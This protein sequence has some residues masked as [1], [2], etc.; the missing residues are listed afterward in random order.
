[1][2]KD[3]R[4]Y[5][6]ITLDFPDHAK[7]LPL[8]DAAFRCL[9]EAIA[10][11]RKHL[12]DGFLARRYALARWS[13]EV[14]A[15]LCENDPVKPS[16]V[17]RED[18]WHIHDYADMNDT[19]AEVEARRERNRQAGKQGGL[20]KAKRVASKSL[21]NSVSENVAETETETETN[22]SLVALGGRVT[23]SN[24]HEPLPLRCPKHINET[25]PVPPCV[26]CGELRRAAVARDQAIAARN[27][28]LKRERRH[29]IDNC[30]ICDDNG[31]T[32]SRFGLIRCTHQEAI[33]A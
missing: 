10:Y 31:M 22:T 3:E 5:F 32:E 19:S 15:E 7:I 14:L 29:A 9:I 13:P 2:G 8:S 28:A 26:P 18:G 27:E 17:E 20:A 24:A 21:S 12:T 6:K 4:L 33:H 16:L 11:C 30:H 25:G 23:E 1:M